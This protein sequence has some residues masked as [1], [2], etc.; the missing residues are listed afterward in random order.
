M[1]NNIYLY[2]IERNVGI[3]YSY[4]GKKNNGKSRIVFIQWEIDRLFGNPCY[5]EFMIFFYIFINHADC[6]FIS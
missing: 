6:R 1:R 3:Y 2:S 4:I 5:I